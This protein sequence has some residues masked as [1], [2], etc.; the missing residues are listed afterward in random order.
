MSQYKTEKENE[1]RFKAEAINKQMPRFVRSFF[2]E[3]ENHL[4]G[5]TLYSYATELHT[6]F[7]FLRDNNPYFKKKELHE[8]TVEDIDRLND[9]DIAEFLHD[10]RMPKERNSNSGLSVCTE[11]TIMHYMVSL[12]R[13]FSYL[14]ARGYVKKNPVEMIKRG[15]V[16]KKEIIYLERDEKN[17]LINTISTGDGLTKNQLKFHDIKAAKRDSAICTILLD[18]G[19]RVSE[20]VGMNL[21]D[22]NFT[23]HGIKV[24]R[25]GGNFDTVYMSDNAE[26]VLS[27][28]IENGRGFYKPDKDEQAVF[29]NRQGKRLSVRS[30]ELLVKKYMYTSVPD[31]ADRIT[32]H[33]LRTTFAETMLLKTGDVEKVQK[34]MGHSSIS[35]T[36]HYVTS[37]EASIEAVRNLSQD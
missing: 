18:T 5:M 4:S 16:K 13:L 9:E 2:M 3:E 12:N 23:K 11:T 20:L 15:R 27:D 35:S 24:F 26:A 21:N 14:T 10:L 22:I 7:V 19:V 8:I 37:T 34:L 28:Y 36:M 31:K 30:V 29:L 33:K 17:D 6:F 32:P 1:A 25:K